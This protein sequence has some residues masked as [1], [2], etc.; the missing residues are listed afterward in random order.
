[1]EWSRSKEESASRPGETGLG[2]FGWKTVKKGV[3]CVEFDIL[4]LLMGCFD[5]NSI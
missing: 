4:S 3:V 1:M 2:G 5:Y